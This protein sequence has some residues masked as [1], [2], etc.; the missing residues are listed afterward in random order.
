MASPA[1]GQLS[2]SPSLNSAPVH[3]HVQR[4]LSDTSAPTST[5]LQE[6]RSFKGNGPAFDP[7]SSLRHRPDVTYNL[8]ELSHKT[9]FPSNDQYTTS[10]QQHPQQIKLTESP[11]M[12]IHSVDQK[13]VVTTDGNPDESRSA[14]RQR[15]GEG[16]NTPKSLGQGQIWNTAPKQEIYDAHASN[17]N[18]ELIAYVLPILL[19]GGVTNPGELLGLAF[20]KPFL[21]IQRK[22]DVEWNPTTNC[23]RWS[24]RTKIDIVALL[25]QLTGDPSSKCCNRCDP[26]IGL[27][28]GC[29]VIY[30]EML[31]RTY[32]GCANCLYHGRQTFCSLKVRKRQRD[33]S[34]LSQED[35]ASND[36]AMQQES[37]SQLT[38]KMRPKHISS[39]PDATGNWEESTEHSD[40]KPLEVSLTAAGRRNEKSNEPS[41]ILSM[42]PWERAPGRIRSQ[43][44]ATPENIA[45][46]KAYLATGREVQ[47]CREATF[48]VEIIR[49]GHTHILKA[50]DNVTRICSIASAG[51]LSVKLD[52]EEPLII[53]PHGMF[54]VRPRSGCLV[55]SEIYDD[56][57]LHITT[58]ITA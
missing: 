46:S 17:V 41:E 49:S 53:G 52:S 48:R 4:S 56:V 12:P 25:V 54:A 22:R 14:K 31:A 39:T 50:E 43:G 32:Y 6:S 18:Q 37:T 11:R 30:S 36:T 26:E 38:L 33:T 40:I 45:F 51:K 2:W 1:D 9:R 3:M 16:S 34:D 24:F 15:I 19:D 8:K 35:F 42:E 57:S 55:E 7:S 58:I 10:T 13:L 44:S 21:C 28:R 29:I 20:F 27:F 5:S 47:V 23:A